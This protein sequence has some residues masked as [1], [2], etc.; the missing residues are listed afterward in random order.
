MKK[1]LPLFAIFPL[2]L[3]AVAANAECSY[4]RAPDRIPDGSTSSKDEMLAAK[5]Q[6]DQYN[7][8]METYLSCIKLEHD[9]AVARQGSALN[10]D[11]KKQMALMHA[12]KNDAAVDELQTVASRFNEQVR[13]FNKAKQ[14]AK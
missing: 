11:Q 6:V 9:D 2:C 12:Q 7:K 10:E 3:A 4:P 13:A 1:L 8:D 5:K 14:P